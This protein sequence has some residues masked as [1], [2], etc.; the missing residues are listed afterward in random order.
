MMVD[1]MARTLE[2]PKKF[3]SEGEGGGV[4]Q[5]RGRRRAPV[6]DPNAAHAHTS[7]AVR[8]V[9]GHRE[10]SRDCLHAGRADA[11]REHP[12]QG[13]PSDRDQAG[14]LLVV[15]GAGPSRRTPG[16]Q[17]AASV[18][19]RGALIVRVHS[20]PCVSALQGHSSIQK[21]AMVANVQFRIVPVKADY[22][23]DTA[24][25]AEQIEVRRPLMR[26]AYPRLP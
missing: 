13:R 15:A 16:R 5:V 25:L 10:R 20:T 12:R 19:E 14:G 9:S 8:F 26:P 2:L 3:L 4:I 22:S 17:A 11:R 6:S 18:A 21:A 24:K 23:I 7:L 1:W